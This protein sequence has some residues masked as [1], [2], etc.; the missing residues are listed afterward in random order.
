MNNRMQSQLAVDAEAFAKANAQKIEELKDK[1]MNTIRL[2]FAHPRLNRAT[3]EQ[4]AAAAAML[5]AKSL[6]E[7]E[8]FMRWNIV[9][10]PANGKSGLLWSLIDASAFLLD[11]TG[12]RWP[13][14]TMRCRD[15]Y[16]KHVEACLTEFYQDFE[17]PVVSPL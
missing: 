11:S 12:T 1:L 17:K 9:S 13:Y 3:E 7:I 14:M 5:E 8:V 6:P 10:I 2:Y 4:H 15:E 16:L